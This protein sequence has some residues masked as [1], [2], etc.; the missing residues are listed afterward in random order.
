MTEA[1]PAIRVYTADDKYQGADAPHATS[2]RIAIGDKAGCSMSIGHP[3]TLEALATSLRLL[4]NEV[5]RQAAQ[6]GETT[7]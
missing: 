3:I 4:A 7:Q 2:I 1:I 6:I 5:D